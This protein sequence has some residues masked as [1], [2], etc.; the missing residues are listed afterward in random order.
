MPR[1]V[2][3][4]KGPKTPVGERAA[5]TCMAACAVVHLGEVKVL[6]ET[7]EV[8]A[9]DRLSL[10]GWGGWLFTVSDRQ[11]ASF[12]ELRVEALLSLAARPI[13]SRKYS[14]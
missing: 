10:A 14:T 3:I 1:R 13:L 6:A 8:A 9:N 5:G 4:Q 12:S 2:A 7:W 11:G